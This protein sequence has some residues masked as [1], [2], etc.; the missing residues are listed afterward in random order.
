MVKGMKIENTRQTDFFLLIC[1]QLFY[2]KAASIPFS[3]N[4]KKIG[5]KFICLPCQIFKK[6]HK[7]L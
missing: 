3:N 6:C 7:K 1:S 5:Y 2:T 4:S